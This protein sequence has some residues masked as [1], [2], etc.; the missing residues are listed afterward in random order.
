MRVNKNELAETFGV[1]L[2]TISTWVNLK[3]CPYIQKP[4]LTKG[5]PPSKR[6]W[7]FNTADVINWR[8]NKAINDRAWW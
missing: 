1:S 4:D 5:S 2:V 8:I 3:G 6:V 7:I